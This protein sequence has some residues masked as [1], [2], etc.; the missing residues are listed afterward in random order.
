MDIAFQANAF[1]NNAF[2]TQPT[3]AHVDVAIILH[4]PMEIDFIDI[5]EEKIIFE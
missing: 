3:Y 5:E 1:Q 2:Q 4:P